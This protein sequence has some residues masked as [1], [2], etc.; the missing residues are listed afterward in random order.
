MPHFNI[1]FISL[2]AASGVFTANIP[3]EM[4]GIS[5]S[6]SFF[7]IYLYILFKSRDTVQGLSKVFPNRG[8]LPVK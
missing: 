5:S 7:I 6:T 4:Y 8:K 3:I 2:H 1:I